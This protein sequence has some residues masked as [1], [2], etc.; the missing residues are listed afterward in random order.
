MTTFIKWLMRGSLFA[1]GIVSLLYFY[2]INKTH[3]PGSD[4]SKESVILHT[5]MQALD[6]G[7][8]RPQQLDDKFSQ[9]VYKSYLKEIDGSKRFFT[10][11]DIDL[12]SAYENKLD[13]DV[14]LSNL[15]FHYLIVKQF[16]SALIKAEGYYK[17]AINT[18]FDFKQHQTIELNPEKLMYSTSDANLKMY[19]NSLI[20]YEI[21]SRIAEKLDAQE[22]NKELKVKKTFAEV[23][24]EAQDKVKDAYDDYFLRLKKLSEKVWFEAYLNSITGYFDPHS[25][26]FS[27]KDK[28]DFNMQMSGK[29]EGI[30]ARLAQEKEFV[31]V[32]SVIPGGPAAKNKELEIDDVILRVTQD[33]GEPKEIIGMRVVEAVT[34]I[35]GKKGTGVTVSVKKK[36]GTTKDIH[37]VREEVILED[38]WAKSS[39]IEVPGSTEKLGYILL[40]SF[41][42][43]F[44][45]NNGK[46][47]GRDV[48]TEINKLQKAGAK[49]IILDLRYNGGGSLSEVVDMV[50]QFIETGPVVQVKS[51]SGNPYVMNDKDPTVQ[52]S[53]PL[54]VMSNSY[55]ASASEILTAALQDY[56]RAVIVGSPTSFGKGTV[57]RFFPLDKM[58]NG[59]DAYKPLG[60]IKISVQKFY[61]INGGSTQLRGVSS[62]IVLPDQFKYIEVGEKEYE[63]PMEWTEIAKLNYNQNVY[64]V[65]NMEQISAMS[66]ARTDT[67]RIFKI[68]DENALRLK[69]SQ[70]MTTT[71]LNLDEF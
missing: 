34:Y 45:D 15:D 17:D 21:E 66:K 7:H 49:G 19:W 35:R 3:A 47:C 50:G 40:P 60:E 8:F 69:K 53:G 46:S 68:L 52:Y 29:Y 33:G 26:Y 27:P 48:A 56:K 12:L 62:D 54:L 64:T 39:I 41:Y 6:Q 16:K 22:N 55:S 28:E 10:Q 43:D 38:G 4:G 13:D 37:L 9:A 25:N 65:N 61:R 58:V 44:E 20:Q 42:S 36:D 1:F 24:K 5:V 63:H 30:G 32:T 71:S 31:K 2:N 51:K 18:S 57:Q 70:E 14:K 67:S 59:L 23:Q 11:S